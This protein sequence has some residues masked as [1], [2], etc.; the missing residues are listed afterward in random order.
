LWVNQRTV[1]VEIKLRASKRIGEL[2][3]D[4]EKQLGKHLSKAHAD[5]RMR[6]KEEAIRKAGLS[7]GQLRNTK[8]LL[9]L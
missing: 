3:A 8:N 1:C 2:V 9:E 4:L 7:I 5:A 6:F